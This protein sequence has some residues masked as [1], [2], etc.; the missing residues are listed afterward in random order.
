M[1]QYERKIGQAAI[2]KFGRI[3]NIIKAIEELAELQQALCK[4]IVSENDDTVDSVNEEIA[5]VQIMLNRLMMLFD[6]TEV[7]DWKDSKL[8]KMARL[9]RMEDDGDAVGAAMRRPP[10]CDGPEEPTGDVLKEMRL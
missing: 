3:P 4:Y 5:A 8:E 2:R 9:L 1:N 10:M 7:Q 6:P